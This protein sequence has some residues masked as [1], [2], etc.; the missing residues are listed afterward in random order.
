MGNHQPDRMLCEVWSANGRIRTKG[1]EGA[2]RCIGFLGQSECLQ[3]AKGEGI[4]AREAPQ[5]YR[6]DAAA[7][8][9]FGGERGQAE[10]AGINRHGVADERAVRG[11]RNEPPRP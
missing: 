7:H 5:R 8:P 4:S 9:H 2:V 10:S 6:A 11:R 3:V 1:A